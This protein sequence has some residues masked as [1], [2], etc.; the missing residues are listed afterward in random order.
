VSTI[1]Y[2][3]RGR[4]VEY[5]GGYSDML[6]QRGRDLDT[7]S[8]VASKAPAAKASSVKADASSAPKGRLSFKDKHALEAL[9]KKITQLQAE[10]A[11]LKKVL[12]DPA[13]YARDPKAFAA[14]ADAL[15]AADM[16]RASAEDEWLALELKRE[17]VEGA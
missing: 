16:A 3:G 9:P 4:W 14:A 12:A 1:A 10:I 2:E 5:A 11:R 7:T 15:T 8:Q 6:M 17:E 13:L